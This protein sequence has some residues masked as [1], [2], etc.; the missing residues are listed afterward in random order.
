MYAF[1]NVSLG[2]FFFII[3]LYLKE[4]FSKFFISSVKGII[5]WPLEPQLKKNKTAR[6]TRNFFLQDI[7]I[8]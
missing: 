8:Q 6:N 2:I 1:I 5:P 4:V 3:Y 7:K